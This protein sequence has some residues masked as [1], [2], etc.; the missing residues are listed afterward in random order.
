MGS[1]FREGCGLALA[2]LALAGGCASQ[3]EPPPARAAAVEVEQDA[4]WRHIA[5]PED[6]AKIEQVPQAW[7]AALSEARAAGFRRAM[8]EEGKLLDPEA[9]LPR[10][11]PSPGSYR[12]RVVKLGTQGRNRTAFNAYKPFFCYVEV[13]GELLTIV[14]QT[15]SERPAGRLYADPDDK[16]LV[17]LGTVALGSEEELLAY[18]EDPDRDMAG[19]MERVAPFRFRLVIPWPRQE[20]KLDVI[21]LVPVTQ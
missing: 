10:P 12:C 3:R 6:I 20:S 21:E 7:Q 19:V 18:R 11:A 13:E 2:T 1:A 17:F 14:K 4:E 16:R 15:G 5:S 9:A 8:E